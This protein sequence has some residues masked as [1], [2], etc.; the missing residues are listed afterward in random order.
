MTSSSVRIFSLLIL[1]L[2]GC[3]CGETTTFDAGRDATVTLDAF[4][5]LDAP[6]A[7][8]VAIFGDEGLGDTPPAVDALATSDAPSAVDVG[9]DASA[10]APS[11][12]PRVIPDRL[13]GMCDGRGRAIC[14]TWATETAGGA[15]ASAICLGS[16]GN[17]AR[18]S[19]CTGT[20]LDSCRCG[21]EPACGA[22]EVCIS[23]IA[24]FSCV[25]AP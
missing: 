1:T 18:A 13:A 25:C 6:P 21:T 7:V 22:S 14:E 17:C 2:S 12:C 8:D 16:D 10:D 19:E 20:T 9:I 5:A 24:G 11:R 4:S 15:P 23:G 3:S